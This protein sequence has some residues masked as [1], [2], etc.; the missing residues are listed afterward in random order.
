MTDI[1][2]LVFLAQL[3]SC[4]SFSQCT[5]VH[6]VHSGSLGTPACQAPLILL[7]PASSIGSPML[8]TFVTTHRDSPGPTS[9]GFVS[10]SSSLPSVF[11]PNSAPS[12]WLPSSILSAVRQ[13]KPLCSSKPSP[14]ALFTS[15]PPPSSKNLRPHTNPGPQCPRLLPQGD[16]RNRPGTD[17]SPFGRSTDPESRIRTEPCR[18]R[19]MESSEQSSVWRIGAA[20]RTA[21]AKQCEAARRIYRE[22]RTTSGIAVPVRL[23]SPDLPHPRRIN[24]QRCLRFS[25]K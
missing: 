15:S 7:R 18:A 5:L 10:S 17:R 1:T 25:T 24:P 11:P 4:F 9:I 2:P 21:P 19:W 6:T 3:F 12:R 8:F 23:G 22:R 20:S 13:R 16:S 14:L